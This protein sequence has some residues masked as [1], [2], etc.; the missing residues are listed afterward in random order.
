MDCKSGFVHAVLGPSEF[1]Q[2]RAASSQHH[3]ANSV[4]A[5]AQIPVV[6]NQGIGAA[7]Q[8]VYGVMEGAGQLFTAATEWTPVQHRCREPLN[9][10][11]NK[12]ATKMEMTRG[13]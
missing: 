12:M 2:V 11:E 1:C 9:L 6:V 3:L 7:E 13:V 10:R 4:E 5:Q 8:G